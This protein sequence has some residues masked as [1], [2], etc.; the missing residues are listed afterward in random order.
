MLFLTG[1]AS[2]FQGHPSD[3]E[4]LLAPYPKNNPSQFYV[5]LSEFAYKGPNQP[6]DLHVDTSILNYLGG[7]IFKVVIRK[8]D[9]T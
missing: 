2:A 5:P 8:P 9:D 4:D 7:S 1:F 3:P 6:V